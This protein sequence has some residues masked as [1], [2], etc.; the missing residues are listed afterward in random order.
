MRMIDG[1]V[2]YIRLNGETVRDVLDGVK[3]Q[4]R[5]ALKNQD[6]L[7]GTMTES[8]LLLK[9][10][11]CSASTDEVIKPPYEIGEVI[12]VKEAWAKVDD[13]FYYKSTEVLPE[14]HCDETWRSS[15]CMPNE[16]VRLFLKVTNVGFQRLQDI[17]ITEIEREGVWL[18]GTMFPDYTFAQRWDN[19]LSKSTRDNIGW[20]KNPFVWVVS[21]EIMEAT[22]NE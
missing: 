7:G 6:I 17:S 10:P 5:F 2:K 14:H 18:P 20:N 15:V 13:K 4:M 19:A 9:L 1:A 21:F 11:N 3:T 8:G 12:G 22:D 16:A